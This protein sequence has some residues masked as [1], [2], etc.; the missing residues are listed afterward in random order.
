M[1]YT[2]EDY[3]QDLKM[4]EWIEKH[5]PD[6]EYEYFEVRCETAERIIIVNDYSDETGSPE[7]RME[8]ILESLGNRDSNVLPNIQLLRR[9]YFNLSK[10]RSMLKI[11]AS[12]E[13]DDDDFSA[14]IILL[15]TQ[16]ENEYKTRFFNN[17]IPENKSVIFKILEKYSKSSYD[18]FRESIDNNYK[19]TFG[20]VSVLLSAI[21]QGIKTRERE[22]L[23]VLSK[24]LNPS[25]VPFFNKWS[26]S[27]KL[28]N[29]NNNTRNAVIHENE[30]IDYDLYYEICNELFA[31][32]TIN[33]WC[34]SKTPG[35][36]GEYLKILP[37]KN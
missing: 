4:S 26:L 29:I 12:L 30:S 10:F 25:F 20:M 2:L 36:F 35:L 24:I 23:N 14:P 3:K 27:V 7:D 16:L 8:S 6:E 15:W 34:T 5:T 32:D 1:Q 22:T 28:S 17:F 21:E 18:F 11:E 19:V 9:S 31:Q 33:Y 37:P 13:D